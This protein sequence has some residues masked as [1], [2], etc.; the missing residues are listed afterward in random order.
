MIDVIEI[1]SLNYSA[2]CS[3]VKTIGEPPFRASQ[4]FSWLHKNGATSFSEMTDLSKSLRE[5]LEQACLITKLTVKQKQAAKDGTVKYLLSLGDGN[6]IETVMLRYR[7]GL[8]VCISSQVGCAMG[9]GF[10][11]S[12]EGGLVRNLTAAEMLAQVYTVA[13]EASEH[14][15][16]VVIMGIGEPLDNFEAVMLFYDIITDKRGYDLSARAVTVS[17]CGIVPKIYAMADKRLQLTLSVSLHAATDEKRAAVMPVNRQ[18][19]LNE[20]IAACKYYYK[21]TGR[22]VTFEYAVMHGENDAGGDAAALAGLLRGLY[23]HVNLIPVNAVRGR[24]FQATRIHALQFQ[25][26]LAA[27]NINATV[28][29]T[30][31]AEI[32]AACGQLRRNHL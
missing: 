7:H 10:C 11:A 24:Q 3:F 6:C 16:S 32:D 17:T 13:A 5:T 8:S 15:N 14:I 2:L 20:L 1:L 22:R 31:G 27:R 9:C 18:Y 26:L 28:R 23:A 29:R 19:P 4:I 12:T 25:Q 21:Q 30:L